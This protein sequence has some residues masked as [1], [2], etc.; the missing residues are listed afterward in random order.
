MNAAA[1]TDFFTFSGNRGGRRN[2]PRFFLPW[3]GSKPDS[4]R[5]TLSNWSASTGCGLWADGSCFSKLIG[6]LQAEGYECIAAQ[7]GLNT[8]AGDVALVKATHSRV[9]WDAFRVLADL[10]RNPFDQFIQSRK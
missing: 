2:V 1:L 9:C 6:P 8:T 4:H 10:F 5:R 3:G 7:Y